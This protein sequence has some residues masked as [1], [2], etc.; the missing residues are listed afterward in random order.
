MPIDPVSL[1]DAAG[2]SYGEGD[3][4]HF[5]EGD[6][7]DVPGLSR[8]TRNLAQRDNQLAEKLNEVIS[9]VNNKE[10]FVPLLPF[11][12]TLPPNSE[13][14]VLN[15]RIP[16]G[17]EAR[18]LNAIV[19]SVPSSSS[20]ELDIYYSTGY[21]NSTGQQIVSTST[22]FTAGTQFY[23]AGEFIITLK[24][25]GGATLEMVASI[26]STMRP[27]TETAGI[28][29]A[30][31]IIGEQG[32]P[33][34]QG[35]TGP[36]GSQG[37][38]GAAGSPGLTW[39]S[40]WNSS[41]TYSSTDVVFWLGSAWK[42]K[43]NS[44]NNNQPDISPSSWEF[45]AE[46]GSP[47]L[48]FL[49][50]WNSSIA[51]AV[52]DGVEY[53]G[54]SYFC[55]LANT[56]KPP[57]TNPANWSLLAEGGVGFRFRGSW[58]SSPVDGL[59][60]YLQNDVVNILS[61]GSITQTYLAIGNP[62]NPATPPPN[63]DWSQLFSAGSPAFSV[64][65]VTSSLY[66]EASYIAVDSDGQ[67]AALSIPAY[68]GTTSYALQEVISQDQASGHGIGF[69]KTFMYARWIGDITLTLPGVSQGAQLNW[70]GTNV[71]LSIQSTGSVILIGDVPAIDSGPA[72]VP[73]QTVT[74]TI[75]TQ[76]ISG[77]ELPGFAT[78]GTFNTELS[79]PVTVP[80]Q[81]ITVS[82]NLLT[83]NIIG[84]NI[85]LHSPTTGA[86][87]VTIGLIGMQVF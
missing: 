62:P 24:N 40:T 85:T 1:P 69:L 87:N 39:Q 9:V 68:P 12:T 11:R 42:S 45:L 71:V 21:G 82:G 67:F 20:A 60:A 73:G 86:N 41:S 44:N 55:I 63:S 61:S 19:T 49:G 74:G 23:S 29:I 15:Y 7:V 10:Q 65:N 14:I 51:Y 76:V 77:T 52:D 35:P 37:N 22:E 17:F 16:Q 48:N 34:P 64:S 79:G 78:T 27:L 30:S 56:N 54:S 84:Q 26:Q 6:A 81:V 58:S 4:R 36:Q 18:I 59:G 57:A 8:P 33:G 32:P 38:P 47:G 50:A 66:A 25:R 13:E 5:S 75:P 31:T 2:L 53:M 28:L 3:V 70:L 46:K 80:S 83:T 72:V 43:T